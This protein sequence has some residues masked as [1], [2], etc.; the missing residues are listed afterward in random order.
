M[1]NIPHPDG[2]GRQQPDPD[3]YTIQAAAF[4]EEG[5]RSA[6]LVTAEAG[7]LAVDPESAP[8]LWAKLLAWRDAGGTIA[9]FDPPR[10]RSW[11][12]SEFKARLQPGEL[13]ALG[14][15]LGQQLQPADAAL[16]LDFLTATTLSLAPPGGPDSKLERGLARLVALG[17][18]TEARRQALLQP[19]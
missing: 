16:L 2:S 1:S 14:G 11:T 3:A 19:E 17:V 15:L 13:A 10:K 7:A 18:L 4:A 5:E 6:V 9:A 12:L 8:A